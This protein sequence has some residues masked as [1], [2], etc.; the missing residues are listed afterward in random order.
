MRRDLHRRLSR[1]ERELRLPPTCDVVRLSGGL[2]NFGGHARA[3]ALRFW[4]EADESREAFE[5]RAIETADAA[6]EPL[7]VIGGLPD[8]PR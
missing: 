8:M 3:G 2:P 5:E 4:Q 1:L 7:L 6:G